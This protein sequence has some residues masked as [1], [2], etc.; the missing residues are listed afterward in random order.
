MPDKM[1]R[2]PEGHFYDPTKHAACPWCA[3]PPDTGG[4]E[5]TRPVHPG[6]PP[7]GM[8]PP[9]PGAAAAAPTPAGPLPGLTRRINLGATAGKA[10]PVV[11]R[12]LDQSGRDRPGLGNQGKIAGNRHPA[13]KAR[14]QVHPG[15][16]FRSC[17]ESREGRGARTSAPSLTETC[18]GVYVMVTYPYSPPSVS[19]ERG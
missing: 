13:G 8:P 10:D 9:L 16:S 1:V 12:P 2:C 18:P 7:A 4:G 11:C 6:A 3:L 14:I 15:Q 19:E 17:N 5:K